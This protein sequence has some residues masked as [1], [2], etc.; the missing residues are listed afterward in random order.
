M[1]NANFF[2]M[3]EHVN[4]PDDADK[5]KFE[6]AGFVFAINWYT[7]IYEM[8]EMMN[9][10]Y[11]GWSDYGLQTLT[12]MIWAIHIQLMNFKCLM[13]FSSITINGLFQQV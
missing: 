2:M 6:N 9:V 4:D 5:T 7:K 10:T 12:L 8:N 13:D 1:F 3:M 11:Q